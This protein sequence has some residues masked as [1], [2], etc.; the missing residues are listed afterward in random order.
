M[1]PVRPSVRALLAALAAT[2]TLAA[3]H[4]WAQVFT[5]RWNDAPPAEVV[6]PSDIREALIWTGHLDPTQAGA[7]ADAIDRGTRAW[8]KAN[9]LAQNG[10]LDEDQTRQLMTEALKERDSLGWS[11][12]RDPAVG[13]AVGV[14]ARLVTF[15]TPRFDGSALVYRGSGEVVQTVSVHLGT[16][17]CRSMGAVF[18]RLTARASYKA[19]GD[20]FLVAQIRTPESVTFLKMM[21]H[22]NGMVASEITAPLELATKNP[23]LFAAMANSLTMLRT[24]DPTVRPKPRVEELPLAPGSFSDELATKPAVA[25]PKSTKASSINESGHTSALKLALRE[26]PELRAEEIFEKVSG[27]VYVV[28]ADKRMG[29]AV[30]ISDTELLTNCHVVEDLAEVKLARAKTEMPAEVVSRNVDADRCVLRTATKLPSWVKVRPYDDIKVGEKAITIGTPQG[31]ELTAAEGIVSSKRLYNNTRVIQTSAP[32]S[33]GSSG[34]GLFDAQGHLLGITTFY[35]KAGQNL[36][37]AVAAEEY[38][39]NREESAAR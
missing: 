21:C 39:G 34:G 23:G 11:V 14:P 28:K 13:I 33:Q 32:I 3:G 25:K 37:F 18:A 38:A 30:A 16:P 20:N 1:F 22:Q 2:A 12:M 36:N 7:V 26:G 5:Y 27:S 10:K 35:F 6:Q 19:R 31:L 24:P 4:A 17:N 9:G 15:G 29:S 8:Q